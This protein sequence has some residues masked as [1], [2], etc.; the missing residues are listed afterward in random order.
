MSVDSFV[1]ER[2]EAVLS[3]DVEKTRLF[4]KKY[5]ISC[6]KEDEV[7]LAGAA[8]AIRDI[9]SATREQKLA[10]EDWLLTHGFN[11]EMWI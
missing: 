10:A 2:D 5:H 4:A 7:V 6:P 11:V 3:M 9:N 8:M 1:K